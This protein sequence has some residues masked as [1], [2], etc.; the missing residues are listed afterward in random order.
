MKSIENAKNNLFTTVKTYT[1]LSDHDINK[2]VDDI[3]LTEL[4]KG[5]I[6]LHQGD[7]PE[8]S[9]YLV[10]GCIR[11]YLSSSDGK[12]STVE[13]YTEDQS[14]NMFSYADEN[15]DSRYSLVCLEDCIL[16]SCPDHLVQNLDQTDPAFR[17]MLDVFFKQQFIDLQV[18]LAH[19]KVQSPEE[20]FKDLLK[21]R[22][23]LFKRVAQHILAS[24]L[25][26][27]PETFSRFKKRFL[28]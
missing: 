16:V 21:S 5:T 4:K 18:H 25:D 3:P 10:Y 28:K 7:I 26:I 2:I 14:I 1:D 27:T 12:E 20:R 23:D 6:I 19:F 24:Y 9:Y 8:L 17:P 15:G 22:P 11:Q 13:F